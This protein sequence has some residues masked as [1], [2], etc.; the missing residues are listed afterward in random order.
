MTHKLAAG[1]IVIDGDRILLI[2]DDKGW[3]LPKGG[4]E[5]RET[6]KQSA[7]REGKE[8]TGYTIEAKEVA[9][10]LE[11]TSLQ[12]GSYLQVYY[13][14]EIIGQ[15]D[16]EL[17]SDIDTVEYIPIHKLRDYIKFLPWILSLEKWLEEKKLGY[18]FYDLDET[19][20]TI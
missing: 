17:D 6:F 10:V 12:H 4:T 11:F 19:G 7:M 16:Q 3:G 2:K 5:P 9:F 18:Y 1:I 20:Y 15:S 13:S 8:E 14:G